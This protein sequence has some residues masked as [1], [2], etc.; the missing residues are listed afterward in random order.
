MFTTCRLLKAQLQLADNLRYASLLFSIKDINT[1]CLSQF[2]T[3]WECLEQNNHNLWECRRPEK[4]LNECVFEKIVRFGPLSHARLHIHIPLHILTYNATNR[5]LRRPS[6]TP[7]AIFLL[8]TRDRA[9][10]SRTTLALNINESARN[11]CNIRVHKELR[12]LPKAYGRPLRG[13]QCY[14]S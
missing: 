12:F 10:S 6:R 11:P 8:S 2:K 5:V 14:F 9:K 1:H 4:A 13:L 7:Q 3:H